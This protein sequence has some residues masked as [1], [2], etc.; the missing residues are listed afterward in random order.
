MAWRVHLT[1]GSIHQLDILPGRY[2]MVAAW[3][4]RARVVFLDLET[5]AHLGT[6]PLPDMPR[7]A[8][9]D[10][11]WGAFMSAFIS[12][13][14]R[15]Y[16]PF[17]R[18]AGLQIYVSDDGKLRLYYAGNTELS[19]ELDGSETPLDLGDAERL[20]ALDLDRAM[21]TVAAVDERGRLHLFQQDIR[22]GIFDIG[23]QPKADLPLAVAV[24]RG[25]NQIFA[26]DGTRLVLADA[27]GKVMQRIQTHYFI[28]KLACST[29]GATTVVSDLESGVLRLYR[30]SDL[31]PT[32]QK[33][34]LDLMLKA[35]SVQLL[36][37]L[38]PPG[39]GVKHLAAYGQGIIVFTM[40]GTLCMS[41]AA[42]MDELPQQPALL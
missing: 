19:L 34:A 7:V 21:G 24:T 35:E 3:T 13:D 42:H 12:P 25:G 18:L 31:T 40:A 38:P 30:G 41:A 26:S 39:T 27:S 2:P 32:H 28:Q 22:V 15:A 8:R 1:N 11:R 17:I 6:L 23:L 33:F 4:R 14:E 10:E 20:L 5:G 9:A 16:L 29:N 36:G 37:D